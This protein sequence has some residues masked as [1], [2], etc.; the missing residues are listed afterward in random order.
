MA[1]FGRA[2]AV[3]KAV[4]QMANDIGRRK[5]VLAALLFAW[6]AMS[7]ALDRATLTGK[8]T[9]A[10]GKPLEH[11]TVLVYHAGEKRGY[12]TFCPSCYA[13]CGKRA[14]TNAGG[15][16][17]INGLSRDLWFELLVVRSGYTPAFV[18]RVDPLQGPAPTAALK[19]RKPVDDPSWVVRGR[20]VDLYGDPMRDAVVTPFAILVGQGP[21]AM[22]GTPPG[23]DPIA[24]TDDKGEF[25]IA[26]TESVSRMALIV[27]ARGMAPKFIILPTGSG[28]QNVKVS[29]GSLVRGR[30]VENGKPVAGVEVGLRPKVSWTGKGNFDISGSP[31]DEIRIGTREDGSFVI[32]G[33]PAPEEWNIYGKMESIASRGATD[34]VALATTRDGREVNVGDL[35]IRHGYRLQ[36]KV[37]LSDG[38]TIPDGMRVSISSDRTSDTQSVILPA[39][40][41]FEF[42]GLAAGNYSVWSSVKGYERPKDR[43]DLKASVSHDVDSFDVVLDP[44]SAAS[45]RR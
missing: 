5:A 33:V 12:S 20:V 45:T 43:A 14:V 34:P 16:F 26:Y 27:E 35:S 23:L 10:S 24:A 11:A 1:V 42:S 39:D 2:Q 28:R 22:Y 18:K 29:L 9:D 13:D 21:T 37:S 3:K 8:V 30:V 19:V 32:A 15:A 31:Y 38:K 17:A 41:S 4:A 25:E 44:V 40:G 36:G 7:F 6:G